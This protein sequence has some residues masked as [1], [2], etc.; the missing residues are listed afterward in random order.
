MEIFLLYL[1][2]Q[3]EGEGPGDP[4]ADRMHG[5]APLGAAGAEYM[6]QERS[7]PL[8]VGLGMSRSLVRVV[9]LDDATEEKE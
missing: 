3:E 5:P 6:S 1:L 9:A 8:E 4:G 2:D 7:T